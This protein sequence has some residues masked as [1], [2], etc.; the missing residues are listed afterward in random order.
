MLGVGA[1]WYERE[2]RALGLPYPRAS[3]RMELV[4]ETIAICSQMWSATTD[5]TKADTSSWMRPSASH[6]RLVRSR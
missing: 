4:E 3:T 6:S 5:H 2:H 1:G